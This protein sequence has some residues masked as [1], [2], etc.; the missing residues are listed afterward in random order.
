MASRLEQLAVSL[1]QVSPLSNTR[2]PFS[3]LSQQAS[4]GHQQDPLSSFTA[5]QNA[6]T[7]D[8]GSSR[9][10]AL[11]NL[12]AGL[13]N[14]QDLAQ[15]NAFMLNLGKD[16]DAQTLQ[17]PQV[18]N[19][20]TMGAGTTRGVANSPYS[21]GSSI[22][23]QGSSSVQEMF[24]SATLSSMGL[25]GMP[26]IPDLTGGLSQS[27]PS[28][29]AVESAM[30]LAAAQRPGIGMDHSGRPRISDNRVPIL[31]DVGGAGGKQT[32]Y[33]S[34]F[35]GIGQPVRKETRG[36]FDFP[37]NPDGTDDYGLAPPSQSIAIPKLDAVGNNQKIYRSVDLLGSAQPGSLAPSPSQSLA[38]MK[39]SMDVLTEVCESE[40]DRRQ[41]RPTSLVVQTEVK[42]REE[43]REMEVD[44]LDD[45]NEEED[46]PNKKGDDLMISPVFPD[47]KIPDRAANPEFKLPALQ[48]GP[49]RASQ[50]LPSLST[51]R[52]DSF[53]SD[54]SS[55]SR[56]SSP[57]ILSRKGSVDSS[58]LASQ[59][60]IYP[61]LPGVSSLFTDGVVLP[62]PPKAHS[63]SAQHDTLT[64][65]MRD[66]NLANQK[67]IANG[68]AP[69]DG[70]A[71]WKDQ[72]HKHARMIMDIMVA[73]NA[74]WKRK[75]IEDDEHEVSI[76]QDEKVKKEMVEE[77]MDV[78]ELRSSRSVTPTQG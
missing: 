9:N 14:E 22:S 38:K 31:S 55:P 32:L 25:A 78:D 4:T 62:P 1:Q 33:P 52:A 68:F 3:A 29:S 73:V 48:T 56:S 65:E 69:S 63:A 10:A 76:Y 61:D 59:R 7:A 23:E 26:G 66:I 75:Q 49:R 54:D 15:F 13:R 20:N 44:E 53:Q 17:I 35:P 21:T 45:D 6:T 77:D 28:G 51:W 34:L 30:Q 74:A 72:A 18:N 37:E 46:R 50:P 57:A 24:D 64:D 36:P 67:S 2:D 39:S 8:A 42:L 58:E 43:S 40:L 11:S 70:A 60:A 5:G 16:T 71:S 12:I 27:A 47:G 41:G 19:N